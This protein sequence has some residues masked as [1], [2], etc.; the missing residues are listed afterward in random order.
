LSCHPH[1]G[2]ALLCA[3]ARHGLVMSRHWY[4]FHVSRCNCGIA[5]LSRR[6]CGIASRVALRLT[7]SRVSPTHLTLRARCA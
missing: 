3:A 6:D 4:A 5:F 2:I 7:A 1:Q